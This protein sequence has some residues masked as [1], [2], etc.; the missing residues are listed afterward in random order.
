MLIH[1]GPHTFSS[2]KPLPKEVANADV[3]PTASQNLGAGEISEAIKVPDGQLLVFLVKK[4]LPKDP[5]MEEDKKNLAK[6]QGA[7]GDDPA[8]NPLFRAWFAS[9]R[10]LAEVSE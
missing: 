6:G 4:E 1:G 3:I 9:R 5:K 10:Q 2:S 7:M 8:A